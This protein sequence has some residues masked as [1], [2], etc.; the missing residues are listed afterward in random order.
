MRLTQEVIAD[1]DVLL[2]YTS[3][4]LACEA[5]GVSVGSYYRW[6]WESRRLSRRRVLNAV[7]TP[8]ESLLREFGRVARMS[9]KRYLAY[10]RRVRARKGVVQKRGVK[11]ES[12]VDVKNRE[13]VLELCKETASLTSAD[14]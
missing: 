3:V 1:L 9:R 5:A 6:H 2:R 12:G 7:D 10:K 14:F 11:L 8:Y 4:S 13:W